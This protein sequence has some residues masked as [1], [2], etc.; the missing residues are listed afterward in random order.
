MIFIKLSHNVKAV[1]IFQ[2][3][4]YKRCGYL[5]KYVVERRLLTYVVITIIIINFIDTKYR[6]SQQ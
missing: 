6:L 1:L 4:F 3:I 2:C 5:Y